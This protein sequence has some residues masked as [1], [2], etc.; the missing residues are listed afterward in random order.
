MSEL[1]RYTTPW[2]FAAQAVCVPPVRLLMRMRQSGRENLRGDG[3]LLVACNHICEIDPPAVGVA[4]LPSKLFYMAKAELFEIPVIGRLLPH[5]GTYPVRRGEAD[6]TSFRISRGILERGDALLVFPEGTRSADGRLRA[7]Q[8]G[9]GALA[10]A[11]G[12]RVVP[13]AIWGSRRPFGPIRIVFGEPIDLT[14]TDGDSRSVRARRA[15]DAIMAE[16]AALLPRVGGPAQP[17]PTIDA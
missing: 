16:I 13:T 10:L 11:E 2:F 17:P 15:A 3:A 12:V 6:R 5:V 14:G 8:P 4:A 1:P 7:A 9:A